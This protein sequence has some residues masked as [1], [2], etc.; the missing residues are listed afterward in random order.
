M[1]VSAHALAFLLQCYF[2]SFFNLI[3]P[4]WLLSVVCIGVLN[5]IR[6]VRAQGFGVHLLNS[7]CWLAIAVNTLAVIYSSSAAMSTN[8]YFLLGFWCWMLS[9]NNGKARKEME[10]ISRRQE[11]EELEQLKISLQN[12]KNNVKKLQIKERR[13][14]HLEGYDLDELKWNNLEEL[15]E[16][17]ARALQ[18]VRDH[19]VSVMNTQ[20]KRELMECVVCFDEA[21]TTLLQPCNHLCLCAGCASRVEKCPMC[22]GPIEA[23]T[24]VFFA[25]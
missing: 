24:A 10:T 17:L 12:E 14:R 21:I 8:I 20:I 23:R 11:K 4:S 22:N 6:V 1:G 5:I 13:V 19:K 3:E 18:N 7:I 2:I 25:K 16:T 15:D 9:R